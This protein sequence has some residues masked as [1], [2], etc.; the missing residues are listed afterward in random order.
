MKPVPSRTWLL[1]LAA[2]LALLPGSLHAQNKQDLPSPEEIIPKAVERARWADAQKPEGKFTFTQSAVIEKL[3]DG[4]AVKER[5]ER[6]YQAFPLEGAPYYKLIQ[7]N[8][9]SLSGKWLKQE[10]ERERKF[11]QRLAESK[12]KR[13]KDRIKDDDDVAFNEEL[14]SKY[15]FEIAGQEPINGRPAFLLTFEPKS[16]DMPVRRRMDRVLNKLAGKLWLDQ[17]SYEISKVEAHLTEKTK[18]GWGILGSVQKVEFSLEQTRVDEDIWLPSRFDLYIDARL[19]F[20]SLHQR[21]K[22]LWGD[23]RKIGQQVVGQKTGLP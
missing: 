12:R 8:G 11:R 20:S 22:V 4:G 17:E 16:K 14:V 7:R 9:Q 10:Q 3:D 23:F 19:L 13:D 2:L 6:L 15:R 21:Q 18:I 5:E 1:G